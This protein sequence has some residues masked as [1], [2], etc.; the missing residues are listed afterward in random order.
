MGVELLAGRD[1]GEAGHVID[2]AWLNISPVLG[3]RERGGGPAFLNERRDRVQ[4]LLLQ[5]KQIVRPL[6]DDSRDSERRGWDVV[7]SDRSQF[8]V[9]DSLFGQ[10]AISRSIDFI[11]VRCVDELLQHREMRVVRCVQGEAARI[12]FEQTCIVGLR[13]LN[14]R[15]VRLKR[16]VYGRYRTLLRGG[17]LYRSE[18]H[19]S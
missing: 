15:R 11:E 7:V 9:C 6:N 4:E 3:A 5:S 18:E 8:P 17:G 2:Q 1:C 12:G 16:N 19:M 10:N 13:A 14:H